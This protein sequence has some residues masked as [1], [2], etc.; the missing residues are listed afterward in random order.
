MGSSAAEALE[1][2]E[3]KIVEQAGLSQDVLMGVFQHLD[4]L[5]PMHT[6]R[7]SPPSMH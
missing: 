7:Q 6:V 1:D 4:W 5:V 3:H 2:D